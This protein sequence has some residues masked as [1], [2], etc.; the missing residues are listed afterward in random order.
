MVN[1]N[2][3]LFHHAL[4]YQNKLNDFLMES[5]NAIEALH[6]CIWTVMLKVMENTGAAMSDG[7]G[8][9]VHL[10]DM[11]STIPI[12]LAF[13][14]AMPMLTGF[15]PE[16]YAGWPWLRMNIMDLMH[17]PPLQS[18]QMAL[19]V[20]CEEIINSLSGAPKVAKVD[21]TTA[22]FSIPS[23]SSV[24]GLAGEVGAGDGTAKSLCTS[25]A[26]CSLDQHS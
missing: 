24:G 18:D 9:T 2:S 14:S 17:M 8:I 20:L 25:H 15:M 7:L 23:L 22:C 3:T 26:P 11:L 1:T 6:G 19:D 5:E 12:H 21:E 16:V 10:V 13:H 4:E